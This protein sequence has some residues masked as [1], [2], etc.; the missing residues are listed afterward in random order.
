MSFLVC[1][2]FL[3]VSKD[4]RFL[5]VPTIVLSI[6]GTVMMFF[7]PESPRFLVSKGKFDEAR[8]VFNIIAKKNGKGSNFAEYFIFTD[9]IAKD[10]NLEE[11]A[12]ERRDRLNASFSSV[13]S[14][15]T[16]AEE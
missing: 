13:T 11:T 6:F 2:Y 9:E 4:W 8:K 16:Q 3:W 15:S 5:M 1:M 7:Q 14:T 10:S 12:F